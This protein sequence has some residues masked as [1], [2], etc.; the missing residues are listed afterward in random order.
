MFSQI[1]SWKRK[2]SWNRC[3]LF[4]WGPGGICFIKKC[5]KSFDTVHF[6]SMIFFTKNN[7]LT[8]QCTNFLQ[9]TKSPQ[10]P[11]K[12]NIGHLTAVWRRERIVGLSILLVH[13]CTV[14]LINDSAYYSLYR[15]EL[16]EL[17]LPT[18]SILSVAYYSLYR[19][20]LPELSLPTG[21][22]L[23]VASVIG[24]TKNIH[25]TIK[26]KYSLYNKTQI[27]PLQ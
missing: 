1:S 19:V 27:F 26:H 10:F 5:W 20:E 22:I 16:P 21:S 4:I 23:S 12:G 3:C 15:V 7:S 17:S 25:C 14:P 13:N 9:A 6:N 11:L 24:K 18:G 8:V 2:I